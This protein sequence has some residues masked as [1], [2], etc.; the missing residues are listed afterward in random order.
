MTKFEYLMDLL[1]QIEDLC[2]VSKSEPY[3]QRELKAQAQYDQARYDGL[4]LLMEEVETLLCNDGYLE[5]Y[6]DSYFLTEEELADFSENEAHTL[7]WERF[8][9]RLD[10]VLY[11]ARNLMA[12]LKQELDL[13]DY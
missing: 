8:G 10:D 5:G 4:S 9:E 3:V 2:K 7:G 12:I 11:S 1:G 13:A 6:S